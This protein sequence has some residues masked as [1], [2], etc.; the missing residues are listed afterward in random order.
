M[1]AAAAAAAA[2]ILHSFTLS[3]DSSGIRLVFTAF[4]QNSN[5]VQREPVQGGNKGRDFPT[6]L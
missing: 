6:G 5:R 1:Q 2:V 4:V 3:Q